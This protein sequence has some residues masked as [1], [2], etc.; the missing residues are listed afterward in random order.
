MVAR[1]RTEYRGPVTPPDWTTYDPAPEP[2]KEPPRPVPQRSARSVPALKLLVG[3]AVAV[4]LVGWGGFSV[5]RAV[6]GN[7]DPQTV[8]G[9]RNLLEDL[10]DKSG[11]TEVFEAVI[12]PGYARVGIPYEPGDDREISYRWDGSFGT[13]IKGTS[14]EEPF[15][16]ADIDPSLFAGMCST[17]STLI[18]DPGD[19]Y[20]I[21]RQPDDTFP[22]RAEAWI[23]AYVSNDFSQSAWIAYD[24]EGNEVDRTD[25]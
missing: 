6:F 1:L 14:D 18:D 17:V 3:A 24:L 11:S 15:D 8:D 7:D 2:E 25:G 23:S 12:Y 13:E 22:E 5:V 20:L 16:L 21:I 10:K 19:C 4:G 9:F